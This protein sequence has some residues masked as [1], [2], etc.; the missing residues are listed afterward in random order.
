MKT[1][2]LRLIHWLAIFLTGIIIFIIFSLALLRSEAKVLASETSCIENYLSKKLH[3]PVKLQAASLKWHGLRPVVDIKKFE[4]FDNDQKQRLFSVNDIQVSIDFIASLLHGELELRHFYIDGLAMS[5]THDINGEWQVVGLTSLLSKETALSPH[6][7]KFFKIRGKHLSLYFEGVFPKPLEVDNFKTN[8]DISGSHITLDDISAENQDVNA[9]GKLSYA[10]ENIDLRLTYTLYPSIVSKLEN[11]LPHNLLHDKL[12]HWLTNSVQKLD[13]SDGIFILKGNLK[14]FPYTHAPGEFLAETNIKGLG[15]KY[16][17]TW[18]EAT[19]INGDLIFKEDSMQMKINSALM[20]GVEVH[21]IEAGI[22]LLG[23]KSVLGLQGKVLGNSEDLLQFVKQSPLQKKIG[24]YFEG[25][26]WTGPVELQIGIQIPIAPEAKPSTTQINGI[27]YLKKNIASYSSQ[28]SLD[29]LNGEIH[30]TEKGITGKHLEGVLGKSPIDIN[31]QPSGYLINYEKWKLK[32][33]SHENNGWS[34]E[35]SHPQVAG[36]LSFGREFPPKNIFG[37][38]SYLYLIKDNMPKSMQEK[39]KPQKIPSLDI[40]INDFRYNDKQF[41]KVNIQTTPLNNGLNLDSLRA[42]LG[43][44]E[45]NMAGQ[46]TQSSTISGNLITTDTAQ[47]LK[48]WG[49]TPS[50]VSNS[51]KLNY[52]FEWPSELYSPDLKILKGNIHLEVGKGQIL[53][54]SSQTKMGIGKL[55]TLLSFQSVARRLQL[56]FSDLTKAGLNFDEMRGDFQFDHGQAITQNM[57]IAGPVAHINMTGS[58][59][60]INETY[61]LKIEVTPHLTSSLPII[62]TIAGGP[63][64][65]AATWAANKLINPL[66]NKIT[67][68][69]YTVTGPWD[70]PVIK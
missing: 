31:I 39:I 60:L 58:I 63:I 49:M 26:K 9:E 33:L 5:F 8:L 15:L 44:T 35:V 57:H 29:N 17:S 47:M 4:I 46:W 61:N 18:P 42:T 64:A 14:D 62:A 12:I 1:K 20:S 30:F 24:K 51:A 56:D 3:Y 7:H 28:T 68:D 2:L 67:T 48:N 37:Q 11:Y 41:G 13:K 70:K 16:E 59:D 65:G 53:N 66:V 23:V 21:N 43:A 52:S 10:N 45:I 32:F 40:F 54:V 27:V 19:Q 69:T 6:F 22:P 38:L 34:A 50:I 55:V 36:Q 25:I